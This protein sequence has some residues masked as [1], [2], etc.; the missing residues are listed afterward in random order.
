M[1]TSPTIVGNPPATSSTPQHSEAQGF[2]YF[3]KLVSYIE[4]R[5]G[6][7]IRDDH[8]V[9]FVLIGENVVPL[10]SSADNVGL[11]ELMVDACNV[12]TVLA[13]A[14][15]AIQRL[16]VHAHKA[17]AKIQSRAFA[18]V[19]KD[20]KRLYIPTADNSLLQVTS[21]TI[22]TVRIIENDDSFWVRHPNGEAFEFTDADPRPGLELFEQLL[23][24]SQACVH[25]EMRWFVAMDEG[26]F[27][28]S[29]T[30]RKVE[31]SL[32]TKDP[33]NKGR[34][35]EPPGFFVCTNLETSLAMRPRPP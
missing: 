22:Q 32:F 34:R 13:P 30:S 21:E 1:S 6:R 9:I 10:N 11:S 28:T 31:S 27:R 19:S 20:G 7:F 3:K 8:G 25:P 18:A 35:Q 17:A 26:F 4:S 16:H 12:S 15:I 29:A 33:P 2:K 24:E 5:Q 23:V 14:R